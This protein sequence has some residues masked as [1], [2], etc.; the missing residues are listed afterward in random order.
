MFV[1]IDDCDLIADHHLA[2]L[3]E[4]LPHARDIGLHLVVARKAGGAGRALFQPFLSALKDQVPT[5]VLFDVDRDE[6]ALF[7]I[8]PTAQ[9]PGR[10][11]WQHGGTTLGTIHVALPESARKETA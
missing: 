7:G 2:E 3:A 10:A 5:V 1:F 6:G 11:I 4:L 9:R 8:K